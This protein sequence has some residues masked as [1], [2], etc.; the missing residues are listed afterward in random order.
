MASPSTQSV[1]LATG[2][3]AFHLE[4]ADGTAAIE[5]PAGLSNLPVF[6]RV[7]SAAVDCGGQW[8]AGTE[9]A[10]L[11]VQLYDSRGSIL[12]EADMEGAVA[13]L[14][15]DALAVGGVEAAY[16]THEDGG[17][18]V[19]GYREQEGNWGPHDFTLDVGELAV[20]VLTVDDLSVPIYLVAVTHTVAP[21]QAPSLAGPASEP[22]S[23]QSVGWASTPRGVP[24]PP[25]GNPPTR[26]FL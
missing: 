10:L 2:E 6:V 14:R 23:G 18:Q 21:A 16:A 20:V 25:K 17:I 9:Q 22:E 1:G 5:F 11:T 12:R 15:F 13:H 26:P 7:E 24:G 19:Y 8:P 3:D 4:T